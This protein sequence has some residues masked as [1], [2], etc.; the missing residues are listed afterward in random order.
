MFLYVSCRIDPNSENIFNP[1]RI[2][3]EKE[4][5]IKYVISKRQYLVVGEEFLPNHDVNKIFHTRVTVGK[6]P[7]S[8]M[9]QGDL[10]IL[11][12]IVRIVN[13]NSGNIEIYVKLC[14]S[15]ATRTKIIKNQLENYLLVYQSD[16]N[17]VQDNYMNYLIMIDDL[18]KN[19]NKNIK[20]EGVTSI[21]NFPFQ[22]IYTSHQVVM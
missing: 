7:M 12:N 22:I 21:N 15:S 3:P 8:K 16:F 2:S 5:N 4:P 10:E 20:Y 6:Y 13:A 17:N 19:L 9:V 14:K 1:I 18:L 11:G